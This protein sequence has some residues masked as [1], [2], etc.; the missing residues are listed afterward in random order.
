MML[1][2]AR[3]IARV[4]PAA[5]VTVCVILAAAPAAMA[6]TTP[7]ENWWE[8][9]V[10]PKTLLALASIALAAVVTVTK[11]QGHCSDRSVH[12]TREDLDVCYMPREV[13][14]TRLASIDAAVARIEAAVTAIHSGRRS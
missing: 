3:W 6:Q 14:E 4:L 7:A 1:R 2:A 5:V 10:D 13:A 9:L 11:L 12:H 8:K